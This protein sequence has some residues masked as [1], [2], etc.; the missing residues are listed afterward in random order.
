MNRAAAQRLADRRR[1]FDR[2]ERRLVH[3]GLE[4]ADPEACARVERLRYAISLAR[5]TDV[6]QPDG[7]VADVGGALHRWAMS[8]HDRLSPRL[9]RDRPL[10]EALLLEAELTRETL[11][12]RR[13][14]LGH[15]A[16]DR[17]ALER[18]VTTRTVVIA[19][20]GGGGAG[21]VYPGAYDLIDRLGLTPSLLVGTSIGALMSMFRARRKRFDLAALVAAARALSW[22]NL[23][24]VLDT[25]SR[26]GLPAT[27]RLHLRG[28]LGELFLNA[29]G[30]PLTLQDT[31]IPLFC[32]ATGITV[33]AL[34]HDL[35]YY[36]HLLDEEVRSSRFGQA[37]AGFKALGV[38]REFLANP[39]ALRRIVLGRDEG[40]AGF[41]VLDAAGFSASIPAVIHYDVLRDDPKMTAVLDTLYAR[42]GITRLGEG[43]MTSN[44]PARVAWET[45]VTGAL[46]PVR[47]TF[48]LALDCFAPHP[49]RIGWLPFQQAVHNA[50]VKADKAFADL[51]V[52]FPRTP[53]PLNLVP[54]LAEAM[55]AIRWGREALQPHE[56]F[57][58]AMCAPI[59][60]LQ[61]P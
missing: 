12:Q 7:A 28:A 59:D 30:E 47:N 22:Q 19:S 25:R 15:L 43:G 16:L 14:L 10:A 3:K 57:I 34:K 36:E 54:T 39:D 61:E 32:I 27:L 51:Y 45:A 23:F 49:S 24:K 29:D 42:Y 48:C 18:E 60:V 52:P 31:E 46:G 50:N 6:T 56:R 9:E 11:A 44:V 5:V 37:R 53:S 35:H 58:G 1:P 17:D 2:L 20:G 13:S 38:L 55:D 21:Y 33:D 40:T 8:V 26:Y 4:A 41:D